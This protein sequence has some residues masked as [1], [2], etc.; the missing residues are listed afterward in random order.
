[1]GQELL[2]KRDGEVLQGL[3]VVADVGDEHK[4]GVGGGGG[5]DGAAVL[6]ASDGRVAEEAVER[7][8]RGFVPSIAEVDRVVVVQRAEVEW[9]CGRPAKVTES[10]G[11][12]ASSA[13]SATPAG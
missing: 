3:A 2:K 7:R 1:M 9:S 12:P 4:P 6:P 10:N 13:R 11:A 8:G 5:V